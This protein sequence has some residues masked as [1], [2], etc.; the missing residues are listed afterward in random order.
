MLLFHSGPTPEYCACQKRRKRSPS[1]PVLPGRHH[2]CCM[3]IPPGLSTPVRSPL[4]YWVKMHL[5]LSAGFGESVFIFF[6]HIQ[7]FHASGILDLW[8]SVNV[9]SDWADFNSSI[10][11]RSYKEARERHSFPRLSQGSPDNPTSCQRYCGWVGTPDRPWVLEK[12]IRINL[13]MVGEGTYW[14]PLVPSRILTDIV[15]PSNRFNRRLGHLRT[16]I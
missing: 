11:T 14:I 2:I 3:T 15:R 7:S 12:T 5:K 4:R 16:F 10:S 1:V 8:I 9:W 13:N 6:E